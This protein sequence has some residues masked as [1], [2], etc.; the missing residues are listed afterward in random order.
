M[1][2]RFSGSAAVNVAKT[3]S[4]LVAIRENFH[5]HDTTAKKKKAKHKKNNEYSDNF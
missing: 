3:V 5:G 2:A 4:N 1:M